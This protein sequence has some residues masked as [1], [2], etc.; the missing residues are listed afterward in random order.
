MCEARVLR[1]IGMIAPAYA[2]VVFLGIRLFN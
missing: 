1:M 2:L